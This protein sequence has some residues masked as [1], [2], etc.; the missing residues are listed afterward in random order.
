MSNYNLYITDKDGVRKGP[1]TISE[2]SLASLCIEGAGGGYTTQ[3]VAKAMEIQHRLIEGGEYKLP[4]DR[5]IT[6]EEKV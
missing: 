6:I 2:K 4:I 3:Q 5:I 1:K